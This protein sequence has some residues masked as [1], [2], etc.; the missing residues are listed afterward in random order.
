M[1][2]RE[3]S[4]VCFCTFAKNIYN[5]ADINT[6]LEFAES[7]KLVRRANL[8]KEGKTIIEKIYTD[9]LPNNGV[10]NKVNAARKSKVDDNTAKMQSIKW[11]GV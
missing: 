9:L 2:F 7:L 4:I 1:L 6:F 3:V 5:M 8:E 11:L 10:I